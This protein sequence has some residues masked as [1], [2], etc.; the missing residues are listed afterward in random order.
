L[1]TDPVLYFIYGVNC[2]MKQIKD[3]MKADPE[4]SFIACKLKMKQIK[5]SMKTDPEMN[6]INA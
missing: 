3:S 1:K 2:E 4:M 6:F 5:D